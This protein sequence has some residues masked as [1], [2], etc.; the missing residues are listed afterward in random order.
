MIPGRVR[1]QNSEERR[2]K[3][4]Q[5]VITRSVPIGGF[6]GSNGFVRRGKVKGFG[7]GTIGRDR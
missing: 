3:G 5:F 6:D 7:F 2:K 4:V 1:V